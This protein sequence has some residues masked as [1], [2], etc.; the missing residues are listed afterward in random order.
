M[1]SRFVFSLLNVARL[2]KK[3]ERER[4]T[5][6]YCLFEEIAF[7]SVYTLYMCITKNGNVETII[8][9]RPICPLFFSFLVVILIH[10]SFLRQVLGSQERM[11]NRYTLCDKSWSYGKKRA[12]I[13]PFYILIKQDCSALITQFRRHSLGLSARNEH[14]NTDPHWRTLTW[15][16]PVD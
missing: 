12:A 14:E 15:F 4:E 10:P 8:A 2:L 5:F 7:R 9:K 1:F 16:R 6:I 13:R 11:N 3:R